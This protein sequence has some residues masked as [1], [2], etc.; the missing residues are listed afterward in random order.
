MKDIQHI[1]EEQYINKFNLTGNDYLP[2]V[3][4]IMMMVRI[5]KLHEN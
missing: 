2:E 3:E 1:F 4:K 5:K